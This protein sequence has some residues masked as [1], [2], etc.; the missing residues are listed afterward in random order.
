MTDSF[1]SAARLALALTSASLPW[2]AGACGLDPVH[3]SEVDA[4]GPE[5]PGV[6]QG[7]FHRAGQPCTV[8]HGA[9]GP[10]SQ[11]FSIAGTVFAGVDRTAGVQ[12]AE[13]LMVDALGSSP[14]PG[15]VLTNCVGNF[16]V[17]PTLWNPAYPIRV[18]V[19]TASGSAM[20]I[21]H[22]GRDGSCA[23][24]HT[25]PPGLASPGHVYVATNA[26]PAGC[27]VNPLAGDGKSVTP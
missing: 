3:Q 20:M 14:P 4:L 2:L 10:A 17:A 18:A 5:T 1:T 23:S 7:P 13:I 11:R 21:A 16:Y 15:S 12:Q 22:I 26:T 25:D 27:P 6:P 9:E 24:C 8:C 19:S